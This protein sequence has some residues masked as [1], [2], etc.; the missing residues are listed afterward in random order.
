MDS[1]PRSALVLGIVAALAS[2]T[3]PASAQ[4]DSAKKAGWQLRAELKG[5][6]GDQWLLAF[7]PDG[8]TLA[9]ASFSN[10]SDSAPV[11]KL[12]DLSASKPALRH[13]L[14]GVT[15]EKAPLALIAF[16]SQGSSLL[17]VGADGLAKI[18]DVAEGKARGTT[19]VGK[20]GVYKSVDAAWV[21]ADGKSLVVF[22]P[23]RAGGPFGAAKPLP[24]PVQSWELRTGKLK[25]SVPLPPSQAGLALSP[26]GKTLVCGTTPPDVLALGDRADIFSHVNFWNAQTGKSSGS[27][28]LPA[29][30]RA[31]Y[32]PTGKLVIFQSVNPKSEQPSLTFWDVA[33]GKT[34]VPEAAALKSSFAH[35]FS[36]DGK[37]LVTTSTDKRTITVWDLSTEKPVGSLRP[38]E[39]NVLSA[40]LS[41]DGR[42]LAAVED[43]D[44]TIRLW[45]YQ[46]P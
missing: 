21:T 44:G 13:N 30:K 14:T 40:A 2:W 20:E 6:Q 31:L 5:E 16:N 39:L 42:T 38:L 3:S 28:K 26:D 12:W 23:L 32:S 25:S 36:G 27:V 37:S 33:A 29:V 45:K 43:L 41:A 4:Q 18:W 9:V 7:S 1:L 17:S 10:F 34:R 8:H 11:I 15:R 46:E 35:G 22:P 19:R 24:T